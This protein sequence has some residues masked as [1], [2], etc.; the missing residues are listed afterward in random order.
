ML[1]I[2]VSTIFIATVF[3]VVLKHIHI[4]TIIG[5]I[6]TGLSIVYL[7]NLH[8]VVHNHELQEVAEFGIVFLMF[9]IGLEFSIQ[10]LQ[11]MKKEV[12]FN[13]SLQVFLSGIIFALIA[14]YFFKLDSKTSIIIGSA[15]SLS[16][17]AIVLKLFNENKDIN[18]KY[19][20]KVLGILLFQDIAVIPILLMI[21]IF[22]ATDDN[23]STLLF[24]TFVEGAVLL[25]ALYLSG[26]YLLEP[27]L[28][29][30]SK[31][32]SSEIFIGS[33]FLLVFGAS[34]LAYS[35][36]FSY[37][38]GAFIAGMLIAETHYKHK[39]EADLIP[40]RDILLGIFFITVGMQIDLALILKQWDTILLLLLAIISIKILV[41]FSVL[42]ISTYKH[43]SLKASLALF[44]V[45]EFALAIFAL[46]R[47]NGLLDPNIER[48]LIVTVVLSMILSPFVIKNI[49]TIAKKII[50]LKR[51]STY[52]EITKEELNNHIVLLGYGRLG[53]DVVKSLKQF[54]LEYIIIEQDINLY[55]E[56]T[57][58]NEN[59]IFGDGSSRTI[60]ESAFIKE[61]Y[62]VIVAVTHS[63]KL[64]LICQT[65]DE[66]THNTNTIVK[67]NSYD[68]KKMLKDLNLSHIIVESE[69]TAISMVHEAM[70][71]K[72][73]D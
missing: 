4:P 42:S 49:R 28:Y 33:I 10:S 9:S 64:Y 34:Y 72:D 32:E 68:D 3:N 24:K 1:E 53:K 69:Q 5:Y 55:K 73:D 27:F 19:G 2:I 65:V 36:G 14:Y 21:G 23:I 12:F 62:A 57:Q 17:T 46:A 22:S 25:I 67:V 71:C 50:P 15:L 20:Q 31:T 54:K 56:A 13:G 63:E 52:K 41:I 70:H 43:I 59:I 66:L 40:F 39:I 48:I 60:L 61:A 37:S 11:K 30:V 18:K 29:R 16:S 58:N 38:L 45:G 44:Q 51:R 6:A 7:F 8:T 47:S 35:L 26:K